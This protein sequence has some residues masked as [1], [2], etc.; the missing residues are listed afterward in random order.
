MAREN[1]FVP[2]PG[3]IDG[4][5]NMLEEGFRATGRHFKQLRQRTSKR[6]SP[7]PYFNELYQARTSTGLTRRAFG[8]EALGRIEVFLSKP[9]GPRPNPDG[10]FPLL[11][12]ELLFYRENAGKGVGNLALVHLLDPGTASGP[13]PT[14]AARAEVDELVIVDRRLQRSQHCP[15]GKAVHYAVATEPVG[16]FDGETS[17]DVTS[18]CPLPNIDSP[19]DEER[20]AR[21]EIVDAIKNITDYF[22]MEEFRELAGLAYGPGAVNRSVN[23]AGRGLRAFVHSFRDNTPRE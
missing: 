2:G 9:Y 17:F 7:I 23:L 10:K 4:L 22:V 15:L 19:S 5:A 21:G 1:N 8:A 20:E 6:P 3:H 12:Q 11:W 16:S 14:S 18:I 13:A